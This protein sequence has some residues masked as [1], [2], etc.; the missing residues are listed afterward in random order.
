[1]FN[2]ISKFQIHRSVDENFANHHNAR[3]GRL[4][5]APTKI[6]ALKQQKDN[7]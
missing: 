2:R 1:M 7:F 5:I 3:C 4:E 6:L